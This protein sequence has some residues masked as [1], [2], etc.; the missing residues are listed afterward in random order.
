MIKYRRP[1]GRPTDS[2]GRMV[3]RRSRDLC[4]AYDR[5]ASGLLGNA[6]G[7]SHNATVLRRLSY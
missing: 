6:I 2:G 3:P 5:A 1:Q 4:N 7:R